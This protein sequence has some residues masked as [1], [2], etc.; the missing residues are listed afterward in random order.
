MHFIYAILMMGSI[1]DVFLI[2]VGT[3]NEPGK[4]TSILAMCFTRFVFLRTWFAL[5]WAR[6]ARQQDT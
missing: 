1:V 6:E 3:T 4:E 5:D 2:L